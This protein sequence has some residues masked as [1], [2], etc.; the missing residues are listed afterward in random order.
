MADQLWMRRGCEFREGDASWQS[1]GALLKGLWHTLR[2]SLIFIFSLLLFPFL[3]FPP[4]LSSSL[5]SSQQSNT[6]HRNHSI[7]FSCP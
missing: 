4:S 5:S 2:F 6:P 1:W 3:P 7:S